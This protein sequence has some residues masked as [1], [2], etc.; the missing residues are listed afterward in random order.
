MERFT[1]DLTGTGV[2][3]VGD[4]MLDRYWLGDV[5]RIS[6]EA[7]VPVVKVGRQEDRLG[8]AANAALNAATLGARVSLLA[9]CGTDAAGEA[10]TALTASTTV[11][12]CFIE[13]PAM[14]T[15][16]K[17]RVVGRRQHLLRADFEQRPSEEALQAQTRRFHQLLP[18]HSVVFFSDYGKGGLAHIRELM[19]AA[20]EAQ[21][22]ILVDP[23]GESY[24][25][26]A[27]ATLIKPN[28]QELQQV[29]GSWR[30]EDELTDK[31]QTL[32]RGLLVDA[33]VVTRSEEGLTLFDDEGRLHLPT[34]AET[35]SDV[36]GA[37]DCVGAT[38]AACLAAGWSP[39]DAVAWANRAAGLA[40]AR[41]G[42]TA[43]AHE[44]LFA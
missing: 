6:P 21:K 13:D 24:D 29:V 8:G 5:E 34:S 36:T 33:L 43:I 44:E 23:K 42:T 18:S 1:H 28:R 15:T 31:A 39:R 37:G 38:L 27:G 14:P 12:P 7:P 30:H 11:T 25:A 32:R 41:W 10:L 40:V 17:L 22:L 2:L 3:V 26:Y 19:Q 9:I 16:L 35:V 4:A 20:R